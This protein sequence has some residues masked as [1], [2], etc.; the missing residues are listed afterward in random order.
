M[1]V[2]QAQHKV[3][4]LCDALNKRGIDV[5]F[6]FTPLLGACPDI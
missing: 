1:A 3:R 6:E 4:E 5:K 2:A